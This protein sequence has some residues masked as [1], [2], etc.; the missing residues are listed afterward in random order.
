MSTLRY[1]KI[2]IM[3]DADVDGAH[4][5]LLLLTFFYRYQRDLLLNGHVYIACPPL[6]K[7]VSRGTKTSKAVTKFGATPLKGGTVEKY[8]YDEAA[9]QQ[10]LREIGAAA[11]VVE[12]GGE[13]NAD[14]TSMDGSTESP[15]AV[16]LQRFKGLGEMM[17]QQLWETTMDPAKRSL[18]IVNIEDAA[19][20]DRLFSTLMGDNVQPRKEFIISN[21][22]KLKLT[23]LDF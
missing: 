21:V 12:V 16:T 2:V 15:T 1:H 5:R 18:K 4:I 23:D 20:A 9:L 17:P 3:T 13:T 22:D 6:Y 11:K 8:V 14:Q 19:A 10:Y 7:V